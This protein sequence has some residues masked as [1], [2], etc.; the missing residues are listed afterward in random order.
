MNKGF[1]PEEDAGS[2][3]DCSNIQQEM[4]RVGRWGTSGWS[5]GQAP[6]FVLCL[7]L[8]A[9]PLDAV[10]SASEVA[11]GGWPSLRA[12]GA[13]LDRA[14]LGGWGG[15]RRGDAAGGS[16]GCLPWLPQGVSVALPFL[17]PALLHTFLRPLG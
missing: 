15:A 17:P 12:P 6:P 14:R 16:R 7:T 5:G 10:V 2:W 8:V 4:V 1:T 13:A 3:G 9:V 11:A